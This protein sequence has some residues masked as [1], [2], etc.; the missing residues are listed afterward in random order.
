MLRVWRIF[1][2]AQAG[3]A[4]A[5]IPFLGGPA[6]SLWV[7]YLTYKG[8]RGGFAMSGGRAA[9]VLALSLFFQTMLLVL[10]LLGVIGLPRLLLR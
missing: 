4:A 9:G 3:M 2:Y 10:L 8:L 7:L 5:L 1:N 6:G